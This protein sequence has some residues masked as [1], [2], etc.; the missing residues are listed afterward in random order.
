MTFRSYTNP[1]DLFCALIDRFNCTL[2]ENPTLEDI[3]Y[4]NKMKPIAQKR[5]V[6]VITRWVEQHWQDFALDS[7]LR[8]ELWEFCAALKN[9]DIFEQ[10][11]AN[12][13][14]IIRTQTNIINEI[15]ASYSYSDLKRRSKDLMGSVIQNVEPEELCQQLCLLDYKA[16]QNI[17]PTEYLYQ[18]WNPKKNVTADD[19]SLTPNLDFFIERFNIE[20]YWAATEIVGV[21]DLK[22]RTN[23]LKKFIKTARVCVETKNFFSAFAIFY[24]LNL[25]PVSRLKKTWEV[26]RFAVH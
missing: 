21:T 9:D 8:S 16:F 14:A 19:V 12:L 7:N 6:E 24:G 25:A 2:P 4:F 13:D 17:H 1:V 15:L 5:V 23:V 22:K 26:I 10:E 3:L 18:I 20:C 11:T